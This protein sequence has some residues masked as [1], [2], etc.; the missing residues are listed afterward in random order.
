[1]AFERLDLGRVAGQ[2]ENIQSTAGVNP[3]RRN[4]KQKEKQRKRVPEDG[5][6]APEKR[7]LKPVE[8][9]DQR[10]QKQ[11]VGGD[12]QRLDVKV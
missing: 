11:S 10:E 12:G 2:A 1:M 9:Y 8:L 3:D 5:K 4:F 7:P 6:A